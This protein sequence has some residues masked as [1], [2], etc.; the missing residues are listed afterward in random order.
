VRSHVSK[1]SYYQVIQTGRV[2]CRPFAI[3]DGM[4]HTDGTQI[5][6]KQNGCTDIVARHS[7]RHA[8]PP[9]K[10][11]GHDRPHAP[12]ACVLFRL[13]NL[14]AVQPQ[15]P[16]VLFSFASSRVIC[17]SRL[18]LHGCC[19]AAAEATK[20][21]V[22]FPSPDGKQQGTTRT[23]TFRVSS[24]APQQLH[25]A[26]CFVHSRIT[27]ARTQH[28]A[29]YSAGTCGETRCVLIAAHGCPVAAWKRAPSAAVI[30]CCCGLRRP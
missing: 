25:A 13:R 23:V 10:Y 14:L 18:L 28:A 27:C 6:A 19:G 5:C 1:L 24:R 20:R 16:F 4:H 26:P 11:A 30:G 21:S 9:M 2:S 22:D 15:Q 7:L 8:A 29:T 3:L 12:A 17:D